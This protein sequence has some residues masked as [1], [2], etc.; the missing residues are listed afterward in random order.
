MSL[1]AKSITPFALNRAIYRTPGRPARKSYATKRTA[2]KPSDVKVFIFHDDGVLKSI[3]F[4]KASK[5]RFK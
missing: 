5:P 2:T 1:L 3:K 4:E